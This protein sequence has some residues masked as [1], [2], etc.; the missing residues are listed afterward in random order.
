MGTTALTL[1]GGKDRTLLHLAMVSTCLFLV[2]GFIFLRLKLAF[3]H[4]C[5]RK[6]DLVNRVEAV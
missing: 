6:R 3:I 5:D 1:R 2:V 4:I